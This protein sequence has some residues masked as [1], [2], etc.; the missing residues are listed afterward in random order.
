MGGGEIMEFRVGDIVWIQSM[1]ALRHGQAATVRKVFPRT[2]ANPYPEYLVEFD[3]PP[4]TLHGSNERF[5]LCIYREGELGS[6]SQAGR[7]GEGPV[8]LNIER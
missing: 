7:A 5:R 4:Q 3:C 8:S 2:P 1:D 6:A